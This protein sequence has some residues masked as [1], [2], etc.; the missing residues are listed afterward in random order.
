VSIRLTPDSPNKQGGVWANIPNPHSE[1]QIVF[2]FSA[3]GLNAVGG[4]GIAF[5]Y[6][7]EPLRS[8]PVF[9]YQDRWNGLGVFLDT[10]DDDRK[11][12]ALKL[13]K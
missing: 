2:G 6:V 1:W 10:F 7:R 4:D 13:F 9:G 11:V 12:K 5:W 3:A 8:G